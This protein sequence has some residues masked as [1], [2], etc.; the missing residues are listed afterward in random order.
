MITELIS[1]FFMLCIAAATVVCIAVLVNEARWL[2]KSY[3]NEWR[4]FE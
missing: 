4:D 3:K 2:H 1:N